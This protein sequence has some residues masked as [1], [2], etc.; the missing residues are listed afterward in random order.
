MRKLSIQRH[1]TDKPLVILTAS[2]GFFD[3]LAIDVTQKIA[4]YVLSKEQLEIKLNKHPYG[5]YEY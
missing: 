2:R 1:L 3:K 4:V 5:S